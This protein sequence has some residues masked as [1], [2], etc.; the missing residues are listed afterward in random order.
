MISNEDK[1]SRGALETMSMLPPSPVALVV[2]GEVN[3]DIITVGM[4]NLFSQ[5]PPIIGI[6]VTAARYSYK[7]LEENDDFSVNF[8]TQEILSKVICCGSISGSKVN[9]F[10]K[11]GLTPLPGS[12]IKSPKIKECILNVECK[13]IDSMEKGDHIWFFGQIV[14]GD[15]PASYDQ[16]FALLHRDGLFWSIGEELEISK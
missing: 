14:H 6:G 8:P 7:L 15:A 5:R 12:R 3:P 10:E 11:C 2:V 16:K 4:V 9:K 1:I 13:K